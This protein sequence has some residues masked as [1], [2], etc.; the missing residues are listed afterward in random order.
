MELI[1]IDDIYDLEILKIEKE[2]IINSNENTN[3]FE[4]PYKEVISKYHQ[5]VLKNEEIRYFF[6]NNIEYEIKLELAPK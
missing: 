6:N 5:I 1:L 3:K 4:I 2:I